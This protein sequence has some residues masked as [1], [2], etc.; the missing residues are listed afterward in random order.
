MKLQLEAYGKKYTVETLYDDVS[1]D[2]YLDFFRNLLVQATFPQSTV[3]DAIIE[4]GRE[5]DSANIKID[6]HEENF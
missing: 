2:E 5:L 6:R 4:F 1:I 3:D